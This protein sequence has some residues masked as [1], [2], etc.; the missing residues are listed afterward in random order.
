MVQSNAVKK[1]FYVKNY[2]DNCAIF[3][4]NIVSVILKHYWDL[5]SDKNFFIFGTL[6]PAL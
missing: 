3:N 5:L 6:F 2:L 1:F 4:E